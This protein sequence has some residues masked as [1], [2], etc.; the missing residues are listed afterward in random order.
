LLLVKTTTGLTNSPEER[1]LYQ[2][3]NKKQD[4][5]SANTWH[6]HRSKQSISISIGISC[7]KECITGPE[8][9][10]ELTVGWN[11]NSGITNIQQPT[12]RWN[13][14][15][16]LK[17]STIYHHLRNLVSPE[18]CWL[19]GDGAHAVPHWQHEQP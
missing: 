11:C 2:R 14:L 4:A 7:D 12:I 16:R 9:D 6:H 1:W 5:D 13:H 3:P 18:S 8:R 19:A 17:E 10:K 15:L